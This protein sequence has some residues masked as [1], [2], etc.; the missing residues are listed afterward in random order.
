MIALFRHTLWV[1]PVAGVHR[2]RGRGCSK[3]NEK[4]KCNLCILCCYRG[5]DI[6]NLKDNFELQRRETEYCIRFFVLLLKEITFCRISL[7]ENWKLMRFSGT[8]KLHI[9]QMVWIGSQKLAWQLLLHCSQA[10]QILISEPS[11]NKE[12]ILLLLKAN[13]NLHVKYMV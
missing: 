4:G 3:K 5:N 10:R 1:K 11:K 2:W 8:P 9:T 12:C 6:F 7:Q 13:N